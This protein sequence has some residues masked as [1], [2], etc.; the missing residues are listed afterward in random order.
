MRRSPPASL[1][2]IPG[3]AHRAHHVE[4][5]LHDD[6]RDVADLRHVF[7]QL[8]RPLEKPAIHE[9]VTLDAS[10]RCGE[11]GILGLLD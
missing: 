5:P 3:A 4:A 6:R 7:E 11:L 8:V 10:E 1:V 9:V 2:Q